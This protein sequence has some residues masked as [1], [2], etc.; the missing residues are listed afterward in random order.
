MAFLS[1]RSALIQERSLASELHQHHLSQKLPQRL[2][3]SNV[4]RQWEN[5]KLLN[6]CNGKTVPL[7]GVQSDPQRDKLLP[8][9]L[10]KCL[11][12]VG[13]S[14]LALCPGSFEGNRG[15]LIWPFN[16]ELKKSPRVCMVGTKPSL[17]HPSFG[18]TPSSPSLVALAQLLFFFFSFSF[19]A[20]E[21]SSA[22]LPTLPLPSHPP[23]LSSVWLSMALPAVLFLLA[24]TSLSAASAPDCKELVRPFIPE[25]PKL[26]GFLHLIHPD[27]MGFYFKR[28]SPGICNIVICIL[29][30][31]M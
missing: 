5:D 11:N 6:C 30:F 22:V 29:I 28:T 26:V 24:L 15:L 18:E 7:Q 3:L 13:D 31:F 12:A 19:A 9:G 21:T 14:F 2:L 1:Y 17:V 27:D 16:A 4:T 23:L 10:S 25:D 20:S 8:R